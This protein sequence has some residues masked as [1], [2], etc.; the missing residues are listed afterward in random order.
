MT[1][2]WS[3]VLSFCG[4]NMNK[5]THPQQIMHPSPQLHIMCGSVATLQNGL[6]NKLTQVFRGIV[7]SLYCI[8]TI[9]LTDATTDYCFFNDT[10]SIL[11]CCW[12]MH[13]GLPHFQFCMPC[14]FLCASLDKCCSWRMSQWWRIQLL[15]MNR[16][17]DRPLHK[18][19]KKIQRRLNTITIITIDNAD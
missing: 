8:N 14:V 3:D 19:L 4:A 10:Y 11:L 15:I 12:S 1:T 2:N 16:C 17:N 9:P 7:Y 6:L 13:L 18:F 5:P